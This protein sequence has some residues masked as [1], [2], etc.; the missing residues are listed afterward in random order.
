MTRPSSSPVV[1][2]LKTAAPMRKKMVR[3]HILFLQF[4]N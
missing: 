3:S 2:R 4:K 1:V